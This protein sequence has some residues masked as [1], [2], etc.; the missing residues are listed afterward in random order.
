MRARWRN[1]AAAAGWKRRS[2]GF[3]GCALKRTAKNTV[4]ADGVAGAPVMVIGEAPGADEDRLGKPF[5]G[6]SGQLM[7][8]MFDAI[9]MSRQRDLYITKHH[10][11]AAARQADTDPGRAGDLPRLHAAAYRAGAPK[12]L[13]LAGGTGQRR[14]S[15]RPRASCA[16]A[17][18]GR[19]SNRRRRRGADV[20]RPSIRR[21]CCGRPPASARSWIDLLAVD[22]KAA[23][24]LELALGA[25]P[26]VSSSRRTSCGPLG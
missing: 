9:G 6:V 22:R 21:I 13:V 16:C 15:T 1:A 5:V 17:A 20:C 7:D 14:S 18:S 10:L 26:T 12:V 25:A 19:T 2:R 23:R 3:E 11:L 4:F 8:H 24:D